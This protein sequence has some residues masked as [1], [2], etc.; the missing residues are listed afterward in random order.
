MAHNI[1]VFVSAAAT[2]A[3]SFEGCVTFGRLAEDSHFEIPP[4][5]PHSTRLGVLRGV[6]SWGSG[7]G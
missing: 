6:E 2:T 5:L 1:A 4:S 3:T 7:D